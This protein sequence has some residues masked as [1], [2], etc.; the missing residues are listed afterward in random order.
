LDAAAGCYEKALRLEPINP[1][2]HANYGLV[3]GRLGRR[4][5]AVQ[6][7]QLA[8]QQRP[9]YPEARSWLNSLLARTPEGK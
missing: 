9:D 2:A 1:E 7:L 5:E 6:H 3:L 4:A 8:L